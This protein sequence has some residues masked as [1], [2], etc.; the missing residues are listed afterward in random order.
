M[1]G[2]NQKEIGIVATE[3]NDDTVNIVNSHKAQ[4]KK[5]LSVKFSSTENPKTK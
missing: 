5:N 2:K 1:S 4:T 3:T